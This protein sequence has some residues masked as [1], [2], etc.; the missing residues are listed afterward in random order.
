MPYEE[1]FKAATEGLIVVDLKGQIAE[2]NPVAERLFGYSGAELVGQPIDLLLPVELRELHAQHVQDYLRAPRTR[3]MGRGLSLAGRRKDGTE[4]PVEIGLTYA[5]GTP[6]GDL[7][8][9]SITEITERLALESEA[10]RAETLISLGT[11][12]AGIAHDLNG[13]LQVIRSLSE[14]VLEVLGRTPNSE[15]TQDVA[16]IH[17]QAQRAGQ[18]VEEFLELTRRNE[19][20][21]APVDINNLVDRASLLLGE[22][23]RNAGINIKTSLDRTLRPVM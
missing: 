17:R 15:V 7:V 14:L 1:Y 16:A 5:R 12:A 13:P 3:P 8:I 10:R 22:S 9:A 23:M 19:K 18:I 6:R 21:A 2:A 11:L 4:F 20:A